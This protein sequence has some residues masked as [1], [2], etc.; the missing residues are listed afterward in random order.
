MRLRIPPPWRVVLALFAAVTAIST[1]VAYGIGSAAGRLASGMVADRLGTAVTMYAGVAVP[2]LALA[3]F[4]YDLTRSYTIPFASGLL[5]L[6]L[7]V[8]LFRLVMT[9]RGTK[10]R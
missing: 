10:R 6:A 4:L 5:L 3:G 1:A 7:S 9:R 8:A 2:A